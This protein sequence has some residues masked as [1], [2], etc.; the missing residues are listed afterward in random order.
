MREH[1]YSAAWLTYTKWEADCQATRSHSRLL[2]LN[3]LVWTQKEA[4]N[5][6]GWE[7]NWISGQVGVI[8]FKSQQLQYLKLLNFHFSGGSL[9]LLV[10]TNNKACERWAYTAHK[11]RL[12]WIEH[13]CF[14][15][16]LQEPS[17][18]SLKVATCTFSCLH[19]VCSLTLMKYQT[20][21]TW[22]SSFCLG[23]GSID[24]SS[25]E[26]GQNGNWCHLSVCYVFYSIL[27]FRIDRAM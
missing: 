18:R 20:P 24:W 9:E 21:F 13:P 5:R 23:R 1:S 3:M 11:V 8:F 12:C 2:I 16:G 25:A 7:Q 17:W 19:F 26:S 22:M 15:R 10:K 6:P 4:K 27:W 14:V